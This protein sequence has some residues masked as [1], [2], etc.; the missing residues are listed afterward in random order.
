MLLSILTSI[1][2]FDVDHA[3]GKFLIC[4]ENKKIENPRIWPLSKHFCRQGHVLENAKCVYGRQIKNFTSETEF[5]QNCH[6][7]VIFSDLH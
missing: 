1:V 4:I 7:E 6:D 3:H 2:I 5:F